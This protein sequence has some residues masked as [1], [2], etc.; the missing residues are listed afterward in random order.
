MAQ[1]AKTSLITKAVLDIL[2]P[3]LVSETFD[4]FEDNQRAIAIEENSTSGE[5]MKHIDVRYHFIRELVERRVLTIQY[6]E[7]SNQHADILTKPLG[8]LIE[9][10]ARYRSFRINL[11]E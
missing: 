10:F 4:L 8:L 5:R 2:Q 9:A 7:S 11:P 1:G 6:T 3:E